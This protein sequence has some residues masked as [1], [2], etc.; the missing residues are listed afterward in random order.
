VAALDHVG[1]RLRFANAG[2]GPAEHFSQPRGD[3][4]NLAAT[5]VPLG[6]LDDA[7]Y[8]VSPWLPIS[9]GDIVLF[10]TDGIVEITDHA[11]EP[12][13]LDRLRACMRNWAG[14]AA[15]PLA[16]LANGLGEEVVAYFAGDQPP[17]DLTILAVRRES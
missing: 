9:P 5:G 3:F 4:T 11:G 7:D 1:H 15:K 16:E 14:E 2:H 6:V 10:C 8:T 17:D 12:F 13:G